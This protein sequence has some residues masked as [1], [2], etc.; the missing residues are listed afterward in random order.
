MKAICKPGLLLTI[1]LITSVPLAL[2]QGTYTQ[3]DEPSGA[4]GTLV[5]GVDAAGD[6]VGSYRDASGLFHGFL[7]QGN[8]YATVDYPGATE[9][10]IT[11]LNDMGQAV[12]TT[13]HSNPPI[14]FLY[15]VGAETFTVI[16]YPGA[17]QTSPIAINNDGAVAGIISSTTN[18]N[19]G[20]ELVGSRYTRI[21]PPNA[22]NSAVDGITSSG[23]LAGYV[24][25]VKQTPVNFLFKEGKFHAITIPNASSAT[26]YGVNPRGTALVGVYQPTPGTNAGFLYQGKA[27]QELQFPGANGTF[28]QSVNDAGEVVGYFLD[29][30]FNFH[31]FTWTP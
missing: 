9:T 16:S 8:V 31:G 13:V 4:E 26:V 3:I 25:S 28:P 6:I 14:G 18:T 17:A 11:G 7:L 10:A 12:G 20:F 24:S 1:F 15:D 21:K 30:S 2:A 19:N 22:P 5:G 27:L 23:E 29:S